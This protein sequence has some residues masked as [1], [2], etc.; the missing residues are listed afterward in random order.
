MW[1]QTKVRL[2]YI[3]W[4]HVVC[5]RFYTAANVL[6]QRDVNGVVEKDNIVIVW[7][8]LMNFVDCIYKMSPPG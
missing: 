8:V 5:G 1:W 7:N 3:Q 2:E 6:L 4:I